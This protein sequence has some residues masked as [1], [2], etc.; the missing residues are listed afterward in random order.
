MGIPIYRFRFNCT[1]C[2]APLSIKAD[3]VDLDRV[4]ESGATRLTEEEE[5]QVAVK[6]RRRVR[7]A[8]EEE[9]AGDAMKSSENKREIAA[10]DDEVQT[11][12]PLSM[13]CNYYYV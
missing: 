9:E 4:V 6:K 11:N 12:I 1:K 5:R 2:S 7:K 3:P 8:T 10:L 13:F